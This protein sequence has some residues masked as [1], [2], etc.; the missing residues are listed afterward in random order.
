[1]CERLLVRA[2]LG[3]F[4]LYMK[5]KIQDLLNEMQKYEVE[6]EEAIW[7]EKLAGN[8]VKENFYRGELCS[9]RYILNKLTELLN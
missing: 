3:L 2:W 6:T 5:E 4:N 7:S 8:I 1:M 9:I